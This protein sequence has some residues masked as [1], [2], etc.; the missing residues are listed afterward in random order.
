[1]G[2]SN[3]GKSG[4]Q[5]P[6]G[7]PPIDQT[8]VPNLDSVLGGGLPRGA[9]VIVIGPPGSGKTTLAN[10]M[11]FATA[12]AG[13]RA[14]VVTAISEPT[15]KLLAHLRTFGFYEDDLVG[16]AIT[17]LSLE[18]FLPS[19]LQAT[20]DELI[21]M[22][23]QTHADLVVLD[24][25][26][27]V[28]GTDVD[29]Q[30]ARQFLYDVGT[31]LSALGATTIITSE[32][33]PRDPQF[34]P[35][36]TTGDIIIGLHYSLEGVLQRRGIE[37]IKARGVEPLAGL[38][39]LALNALG[40]IVFPRLESRVTPRPEAIEPEPPLVEF[41][42]DPAAPAEDDPPMEKATFGLAELDAVLD[43]GITRGTSTLVIGSL[44]T[45][46]TLLALHFAIAGVRA[47]E[48]T[49]FLGFRENQRRLLQKASAFDLGSAFATEILPGGHLT[50]QRWAPVEMK[51]DIVADALL[52]ALDRTGARRLVVDSIL[53]IE[54]TLIR[55][56]PRRTNDY[57]AA[58]IE[59]LHQRDVTALFIKELRATVATELDLSAGPISVL[60]E[61]VLLLQQ[62]EYQAKLHR[63]F[64]VIKM[65]FSAHDSLLHEFAIRAPQGIELLGLFQ[66]DDVPAAR[67]GE[68]STDEGPSSHAA[69]SPESAP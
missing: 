26:R 51:V 31:M 12:H 67:H 35:E 23:R 49:V 44:G 21:A 57:L 56:D 17:F 38:H 40:V 69:V 7:G 9:L 22:A 2:T 6:P 11:A 27:G 15:S 55:G 64:S 47:G 32:A 46:K 52:A 68:H 60:A 45:G 20:G 25:F 36:A 59:A 39:A 48:P 19:G 41:A 42:R 65:R 29:L 8:G 33:D 24:G 37:V 30:A 34:F 50:L 13:R 66:R 16:N 1:M 63:V 10:Q 14:V 54:S 43:G 58:L 5:R 62:L 18:Q 61:N 4:E 3:L 53:E 28:R